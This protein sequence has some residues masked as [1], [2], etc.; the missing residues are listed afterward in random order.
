MLMKATLYVFNVYE[1]CTRVT[2]RDQSTGESHHPGVA[3]SLHAHMCIQ[4]VAILAGDESS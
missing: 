3:A 1:Y 4:S 2:L